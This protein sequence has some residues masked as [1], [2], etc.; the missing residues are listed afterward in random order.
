MGIQISEINIYRLTPT[1]SH[2]MKDKKHHIYIYIALHVFP[3]AIIQNSYL[4]LTRPNVLS[5][6]MIFF[7]IDTD[8]IYIKK[9]F[10]L[11]TSYCQQTQV[12]LGNKHFPQINIQNAKRS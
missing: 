9:T 7:I 12:T 11:V 6:S 1:P 10:T 2:L 4:A 3:R 8:C 5:F